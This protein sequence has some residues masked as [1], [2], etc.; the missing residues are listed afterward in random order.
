MEGNR[1]LGQAAGCAPVKSQDL[2]VR[3]R[4]AAK[5]KIDALLKDACL[6]N[7]VE[8]SIAANREES[9][10]TEQAI[11]AKLAGIDTWAR[12]SGP[13]AG[14][15]QVR[16]TRLTHCNGGYLLEIS[17]YNI[18]LP[19]LT[20]SAAFAVASAELLRRREIRRNLVAWCRHCGFEPA[21]HHRLLLAGLEKIA[22]GECRRL[23]AFM[24]PGSAKSTY[25]SVLF[26]PHYMA[27]APGKSII[28]ASHTVE[29]AEKWWRRIR[30]LVGEHGVTLGIELSQESQ[31]AG[32]WALS[33]GGEY[34]AAASALA[35]RDVRSACDPSRAS[36]TCFAVMHSSRSATC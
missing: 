20:V 5:S 34:Y 1:A 14:A 33:S 26:P 4:G 28:A 19:T 11:A 36:T 12:A 23:A 27:N 15:T 24:P 29:L 2:H 7:P 8:A 13:R 21:A 35:S 32:P 3:L 25:G 22:R 9:Q 31:A 16:H 18:R 10:K 6:T 30:S 17:G